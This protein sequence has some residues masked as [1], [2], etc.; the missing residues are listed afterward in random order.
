MQWTA[1][2]EGHIVGDVDER[3]DRP[4]PDGAQTRLH[5]FRRRLVGDAA[6]QPQREGGAEM[7]VGRR[8]IEANP[9]RAIE[10][11]VECPGLR[12]PERAEAGRGEIA[13]DAGDAR[14]IGA[15]RRQRHVDH[16]IVEA[17]EARVGDADR[18]V[19]RQLHDAVV[20]VAELELGRRAQHAVR[21]D[22]ADHAL[23]EGDVFSRDVGPD[24]RE[25][26]LHAGSRV[27]RAAHDLHRTGTRLDRADPEP[28]GVGML[29]GLD[30]ITD[31][32]ARVFG[33]RVLDAF[34]LEADARQRVDDLGERGLR[35]E[36]VLEPG[37]GEF[38]RRGS[39]L[40]R[41]TNRVASL[42]FV[43]LSRLS[44]SFTAARAAA[45]SATA[46]AR[47][48]ETPSSVRRGSGCG[49]GL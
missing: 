22:A 40:D 44:N 38:H 29:F 3:A 8:E 11:A 39:F 21:L 4:E 49:S 2:V 5:P 20:I 28:V 24:R 19:V 47:E 9:G 10:A 46:S 48:K 30:D 43:A 15:V 18:G 45:T 17:G 41:E 23:A 7:R 42:S 34:D 1:A 33:A 37:E 31:N 36:M 14:R 6:H 35:V 27:G 13:R 12:R 25:H 16:R 26:A 32:E